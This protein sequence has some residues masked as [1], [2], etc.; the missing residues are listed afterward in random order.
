[1]IQFIWSL[2]SYISKNGFQKYGLY[3]WS[4]NVI[5]YAVYY[6]FNKIGST[7]ADFYGI[8]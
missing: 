2:I 7:D 5:N 4:S 8:F 1:M 3:P 6:R